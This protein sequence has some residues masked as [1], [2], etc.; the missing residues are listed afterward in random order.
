MAVSECQLIAGVVEAD[1]VAAE[2]VNRRR[3]FH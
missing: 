1:E 3:N 2:Y